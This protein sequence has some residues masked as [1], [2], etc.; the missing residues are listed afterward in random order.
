MDLPLVYRASLRCFMKQSLDERPCW[1]PDGSP[2]SLDAPSLW[3]NRAGLSNDL[4]GI[5]VCT[6][7]ALPTNDLHR[8]MNWLMV[9]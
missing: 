9:G 5:F 8:F 1:I 4:S 7:N 6:C 3:P 2:A